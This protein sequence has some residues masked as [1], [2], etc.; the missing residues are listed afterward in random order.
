MDDLRGLRRR[1][2]RLAKRSGFARA[3]LVPHGLWV[4]VLLGYVSHTAC[5]ALIVGSCRRVAGME[6]DHLGARPTFWSVSSR[7]R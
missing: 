4:L 7:S 1:C 5:F 2:V 3:M 6:R